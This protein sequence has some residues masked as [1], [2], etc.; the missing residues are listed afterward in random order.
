M[1]LDLGLYKLI[2]K[3]PVKIHNTLEWAKQME[4]SNRRISEDFIET[5]LG[6]VRISTV[7]LGID[8]NHFG[9]VPI[10]FE[11]MIFGG[12]NDQYQKRYHTYE[13]AEANHKRI[14]EKIKNNHKIVLK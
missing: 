7:F 14:V 2:D 1:K 6:I 13:G 10:L 8:H 4:I 3:K 5:E 9:G 11:T 12:L